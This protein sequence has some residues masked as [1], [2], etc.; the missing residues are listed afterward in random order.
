MLRTQRLRLVSAM[1]AMAFCLA[2]AIPLHAQTTSASVAGA[3]KDAKGGVLPG[4]SVTLTSETQGTEMSV[5]TDEL[6]N[7]YFPIVRPDTYT[8]K[9]ALQGF[10][11]VQTPKLV[12]NANDRLSAGTFTMTLGQISES[13]TVTGQSTDIQIRSGERAFTLQ[14]SAIQNIAVNGRSFFGLAVLVP[15]VIPNSDTPTQ[16]SNLNANGQR[17]NSNN[18]TIDGVANI[19]TGNNGGNMAQTNL[20]AIAEFKVLTSSYQAEYGR[21]LG[22]QVQAVTKSGTKDFH[23]SAYWYARRS[24]WNANSWMNNRNGISKSASKRND[25]GWSLGGPV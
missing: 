23:G 7:F 17:S 21:A 18:M 16:V 8:L 1:L 5:V 14:T 11:T 19:D 6:G 9:I 24:G 22:A 12:V 4:A 25:F 15:G 13:I 3:V 2:V 10:Q 20:D